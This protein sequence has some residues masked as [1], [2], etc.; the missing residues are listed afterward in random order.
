[1]PHT[2]HATGCQVPVPPKMLMCRKHWYMVPSPLRREV[3]RLY[4]PGQEIDKR[5][6]PEYLDVMQAAIDA[7]AEKER[8]APPS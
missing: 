5:P 3:W 8:I 2:C 1:M 4:R 7:V 6:S